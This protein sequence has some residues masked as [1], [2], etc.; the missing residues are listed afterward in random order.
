MSISS[1]ISFSGDKCGD[2]HLGIAAGKLHHTAVA[3]TPLHSQL[4]TITVGDLDD[5]R[6]DQYL[7]TADIET[8]D[9]LLDLLHGIWLSG[10]NQRISL[11]VS[12][13]IQ[14]LVAATTRGLTRFLIGQNALAH[15]VEDFD[16]ILG[17]GILEIEDFGITLALLIPIQ[18]TDHLQHALTRL[19]IARNHHGVGAFI[20]HHLGGQQRAHIGSRIIFGQCSY[21]TDN[22]RCRGILKTHNIHVLIARLVHATHD[23]DQA[24]NHHGPACD[25][26]N[27]GRFIM[28]HVTAT[29]VIVQLTQQRSQLAHGNVTHRYHAGDHLVAHARILIIHHRHTG[30]L[31]RVGA[32]HLEHPVIHGDHGETIDIQYTQEKLVV[33]LFIEQVITAHIDLAAH[34]RLD[35]DGL[36]EI[37]AD[38]ID[39]FLN[40]RALEASGK[41]GGTNWLTCHQRGNQCSGQQTLS[42]HFNH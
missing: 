41:L 3:V 34:R 8:I 40:V 20:C 18:L 24:I 22:F 15:A 14:L 11:F 21:Q 1:T 27:V 26:Q 12:L 2:R 17:L 39:K 42:S 38:G 13:D 35:N 37:L 30:R 28:H 23:I 25:Q 16:Q 10:N 29:G 9:H 6:L 19:G 32:Q 31:G 4:G 36:V 33:L 5:N 7:G